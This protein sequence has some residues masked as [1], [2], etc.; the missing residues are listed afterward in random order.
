MGIGLM[1]AKKNISDELSIVVAVKTKEEDYCWA[2]G[3]KDDN[4]KVGEDRYMIM[5]SFSNDEGKP[6][7]DYLEF[8][9]KHL[10]FLLNLGLTHV[11]RVDKGKEKGPLTLPMVAPISLVQK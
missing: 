9:P 11:M 8:C 10:G 1:T 2:C 6:D 5:A 4:Q 3:P 7:C